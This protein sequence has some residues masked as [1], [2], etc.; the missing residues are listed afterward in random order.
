MF[1]HHVVSENQ[2]VQK[3]RFK[4]AILDS[5]IN[6]EF[7]ESGIVDEFNAIDPTSPTIDEMSHGTPIANIIENSEIDLIDVK[8][9]DK[10][11]KG[12]AEDLVKAIEWCIE[13]EVDIININFGYQTENLA[14]KTVIGKAVANGILIIAAAGNT[15]GFGVDYPAKYDEVISITATDTELRRLSSTGKGKI[16]F[17][18][19]GEDVVAIDKNGYY[20]KFTGTSFATAKATKYIASLMAAK[21]KSLSK[22]SIVALLKQQAKDLGEEGLDR[23]YGYG[24]I[25]DN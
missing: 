3:E 17:A 19:V 14:V 1:T 2:E 23:E 13:Q 22:E 24:V 18:F 15:F 5:G 10:D 9:L 4:V 20:R 16:D 7:L 8:V 11:G 6:E 21:K 25:E 12:K